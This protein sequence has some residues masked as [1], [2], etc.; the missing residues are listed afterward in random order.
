M[1][2]QYHILG[3]FSFGGDGGHNIKKKVGE[4]GWSFNQFYLFVNKK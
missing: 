4:K 2:T 1:S 3:C